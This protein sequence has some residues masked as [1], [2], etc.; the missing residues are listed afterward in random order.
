MKKEQAP[1]TK[2][3]AQ[4]TV[5]PQ[6]GTSDLIL[7]YH[8]S[9]YDETIDAKGKR[10][11]VDQKSP[12]GIIPTLRSLF[13][14]EPSGAW[15]SWREDASESFTEDQRLALPPPD[16]YI[17]RR[18]PL[19]PAKIKSFYHVTSKE[20]LW[21]ILHSFPGLFNVENSD[22]EIFAEVN[23]SFARAAC[24]EAAPGAIIWIHDYNLWL[25]PAQIRELRPD[26]RIAFFH[27]TP[28]PSNDVF[29]ILPWRDEILDSL[30]SCDLVGFHIPRY[31]DNFSR[32]AINLRGARCGEPVPVAEKFRPQ[33]SA[34]AQPTVIPWLDHNGRRVH[35]QASPVGTS[36]GTIREIAASEKVRTMAARI[37]QQHAGRKLI[38]AASRVD[39]TKG[40]ED[41]L[42]TYERLLEQQPE[43]HGEVELFLA[44]VAAASGM[45][46][47][48]DIQR[49][50]EEIVGRIN[51][52]FGRI[53]W[54]PVRLSTRRT[55][56]DEL[57][58]W[59]SQSDVCWIT[60]LRDGLNLVA[61]E[62]VAARHGRD[63]VL[64]LS[65]FC[66]ASVELEDAV[67]T[68]PYSHMSMDNA[69]LTALRMPKDEQMR[70]M[71]TMSKAVEEFT[72]Q[73]WA[74]QELGALRTI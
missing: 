2:A 48:D 35:I 25:V 58:A 71:A 61:K 67:I 43:W 31:A 20:S 59:F 66:G 19:T 36:P 72:V 46:I 41:M 6:I 8:R 3:N 54:R 9:P 37:A 50:V 29:S 62:Y 49:S 14:K 38:I 18:L 34:L 42:L 4:A 74:E 32:T 28:F 68:N 65:E 13:H 27:H 53:D 5:P 1:H 63:G 56:Y 24:E 55:P 23:L 12:N 26:V 11:W 69:I 51:G 30:L 45:R 70:R 39:Y 73:H 10:Q 57:I 64:V 15:I 60:P 44:C 17:L 47:Y 16:T 22:W 21:P 33:G 7:V 52:R 40:N